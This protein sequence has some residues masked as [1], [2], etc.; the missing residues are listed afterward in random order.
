MGNLN[1]DEVRL[2]AS[3]AWCDDPAKFARGDQWRFATG[4]Y[5]EGALFRL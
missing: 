1:I 3:P 2:V 4:I 5:A